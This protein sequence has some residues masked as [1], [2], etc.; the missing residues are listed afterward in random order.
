VPGESEEPSLKASIE[1]PEPLHR[2]RRCRG[3]TVMINL[4]QSYFFIP[5]SIKRLVFEHCTKNVRD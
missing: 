4:I 2:R 3:K 1:L 5:R